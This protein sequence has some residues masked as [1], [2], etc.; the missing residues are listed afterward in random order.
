M[1]FDSEIRIIYEDKDFV[2]INKPA[3]V[4]VHPTVEGADYTGTIVGWLLEHYPEIKTVGDKPNVRPGI[5][6][7]LDKDTSGVLLVCRTQAFFEHMKTQF[8][9]HQVIK[10]YLALV[11]GAPKAEGVIDRAIGLRSGSVKRSVSARKMKMIKPAITEYKTIE[12]FERDGEKYSLVRLV[13]KTG[14]THQ[15]RVHMAFIGC[16]VVGDSLYGRKENTLGITRQ[17][18]HAESIEFSLSNGKRIRTEA[19]LSE[20]LQQVLDRL[21]KNIPEAQ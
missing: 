8:Q 10:S 9:L 3:G 4:L 13:P 2:A 5:V 11:Y 18:L 6:H 7:R 20:D 19:E 15:L 12:T 1:V 21:E 16:P 14:R 17:F